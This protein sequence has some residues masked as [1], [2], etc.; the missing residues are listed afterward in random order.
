MKFRMYIDEVGNS[1]LGASTNPNHRYLS[2]SGVI[3][4]LGYVDTD[5]FPCIEALKRKYFSS[6]ADD[7]I[8]L[9]RKDLLNKRVPF[10][11]LR[12]QAVERAFNEELLNL[13]DN[14]D[15]T[16]LTVIVDK[17]EHMQRYKTWRF[18]PYHYA[19]TVIV[20]RYVLW[21]RARE[22]QGDVLA[23]SRGGKDDRRLKDSF[24]MLYHEGSEFINA[25]EFKSCLTSCQL[26][27]KAKAN[28][29]AGLQIAD[30]I[31]H[32]S[33]KHAYCRRTTQPISPSFGAR[34]AEILCSKKYYRKPDGTIDGWG[35]KW[36][37]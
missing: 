9:H 34:I 25:S 21:L 12:D 5:V 33:F 29:I 24:Q 6:H 3:M 1:D 32:P 11:A 22:A 14:T 30:L 31:A 28:N 15:Y 16:V 13:L 37:P 18:D 36:L 23:E 35:I 19:L 8:V 4:E 20:E 17:L 7:P 2:L 26:K 10:E 27:V